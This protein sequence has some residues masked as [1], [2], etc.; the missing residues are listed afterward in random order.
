MK[1]PNIGLRAPSQSQIQAQRVIR[2]N[3]MAKGI[4]H[5][6][7]SEKNKPCPYCAETF[8][9]A[10][11]VKTHIN[12]AHSNIVELKGI[13]NPSR[14]DTPVLGMNDVTMMGNNEK[15][16]VN[17]IPVSGINISNPPTQQTS[18]DESLSKPMQ[19][20]TDRKP[21]I[22]PSHPKSSIVQPLPNGVELGY[23][24]KRHPKP[25]GKHYR[26]QP[27]PK[28]PSNASSAEHKKS[29]KPEFITVTHGIKKPKKVRHFCCKLCST[30]TDSQASANHHYHTN[31]PLIKC[32][33]CE[34][35][36]NN[37]NSLR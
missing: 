4:L 27:T 15:S 7:D 21:K 10:Q 35:I 23:H 17:D 34:A 12:H 31:H 22:T 3:K 2:S 18:Q 8:Y 6:D 13:D 5:I 37:P 26:P 28:P 14:K 16:E 11:T 1:N 30:V 9:Y 32:D 29:T 33:K 19:S 36:F 20:M 24:H 25:F